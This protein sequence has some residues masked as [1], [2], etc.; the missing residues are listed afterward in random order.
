V[1]LDYLIY[2]VLRARFPLR[3]DALRANPMRCHFAAAKGPEGAL[4]LLRPDAD[5]IYR[6]FKACLAVPGGYPG[7]VT[8]DGSQYLDG[9]VANPLPVRA[10]LDQGAKRILAV[11]AKPLGREQSAP[12][13]L[14]KA[15]LWKYFSKYEWV[16]ERINESVHVHA[17]EVSL[18]RAMAKHNPPEAFVI[19]PDEDLPMLFI[20]RDPVKINR[21]VNLGYK[22]VVELEGRLREF[23]RPVETRPEKPVRPKVPLL[24]PGLG[25]LPGR[26]LAR[27]LGL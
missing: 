1:N 27:V 23:L 20:T 18:L 2:D 16:L 4:T 8:V 5:D 3:L 7:T 26:L 6:I 10:L 17:E 22:K 14:E 15:M 9:A 25:A 12:S 11:L 13:L 24:L 21:A 19:C